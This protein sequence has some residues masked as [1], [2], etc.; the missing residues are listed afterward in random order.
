MP[1]TKKELIKI[2]KSFNSGT[3]YTAFDTETTG[4]SPDYCNIIEIGAVKFSKDGV[5]RTFNTLINPGYPIPAEIT[6]LTSITTAQVADAPY[7][8]DI[9]PDFLEFITGTVLVA[10]NCNFDV[11]F[12][13]N[14]LSRN[15]FCLLQQP[16]IPAIDTLKTSRVAFPGLPSYKQ[17]NLA[18]I[19]N[20][21]VEHAHRANDDARVCMELFLKCLQKVT[22]TDVP[23]SEPVPAVNSTAASLASQ[24]LFD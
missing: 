23:L 11:K 4:L 5:L 22:G 14:E 1:F 8:K 19:L 13:N 16:N 17:A 15:S 7:F 12:V 3:I 21:S 24:A 9:A 6:R 2:A 20:I 18:N 10:H